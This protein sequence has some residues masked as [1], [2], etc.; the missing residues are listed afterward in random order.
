MTNKDPIYQEWLREKYAEFLRTHE[1]L[2]RKI[3]KKAIKKLTSRAGKASA[4]KLTPRQ[5]KERARL[6]GIASGKARRK[7]K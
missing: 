4:S 3:G 5:R 6:A 1:D 2:E 7:K